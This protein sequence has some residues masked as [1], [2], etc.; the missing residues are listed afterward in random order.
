MKQADR[1]RDARR[2][3]TAAVV[4]C[5]DEV[6]YAQTTITAVQ[7]A[8]G[9]SR[10]AVL[11]HYPSKLE[12]MTATAQAVLGSAVASIQAAPRGDLET[13][14]LNTWRGV[15]DTPSG[16]AFL[17]ILA[18]CRTDRELRDA[19][20]Q[21]IAAWEQGLTRAMFERYFGQT[22]APDD[23]VDVLWG[24][25][26]A[27]LRGLLLETPRDPA[28]AERRVRLFARMLTAHLSPTP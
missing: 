24:V 18:A 7:A 10:G 27:F 12:L 5:L 2:R 8:A 19:V 17:E 16:R 20:Q 3:L 15:V 21:V 4:R 6:G 22:V 14:V 11:H 9:V 25:S 26:R 23:D 13:Q 28:R 1:R